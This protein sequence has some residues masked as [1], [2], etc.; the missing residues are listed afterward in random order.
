MLKIN[1][2]FLKLQDSYLFVTITN[3]VKEYQEK[4]PEQEIILL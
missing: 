1:E 3:K 2:N 4:N